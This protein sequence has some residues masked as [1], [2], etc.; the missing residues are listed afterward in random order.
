MEENYAF[1]LVSVKVEEVV[2]LRRQVRQLSREVA[3]IK[4][5]MSDEVGKDNFGVWRTKSCSG[6]YV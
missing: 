1:R 4:K 6:N 5:K 2:K 3:E